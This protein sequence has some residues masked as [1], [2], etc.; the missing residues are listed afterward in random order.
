MDKTQFVPMCCY[1]TNE[2]GKPE[3][4]TALHESLE[5]TGTWL[6]IMH[7]NYTSTFAVLWLGAKGEWRLFCFVLHQGP[8]LPFLGPGY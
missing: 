7:I 3:Q 8:I 1:G 5:E 4:M 2:S 6:L